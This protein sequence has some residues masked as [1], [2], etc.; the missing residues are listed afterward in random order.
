L[1]VLGKLKLWN[2]EVDKIDSQREKHNKVSEHND[3][4]E[5]NWEREKEF[6]GGREGEVESVM[7]FKR[8]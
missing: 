5:N 1:L 6:F 7:T 8:N 3:I 2:G 4:I